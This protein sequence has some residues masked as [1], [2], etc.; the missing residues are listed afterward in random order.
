LTTFAARPENFAAMPETVGTM[1]FAGVGVD[2]EEVRRFEKLAVGAARWRLVFT[3]REAE[4]LAAQPRPAVAFC[5]AFCCKEA[6]CKALG[7]RYPFVECECR[8]APGGRVAEVELAP[9]LRERHGVGGIRMRLRE[10]Y[11]QERGE[12]VVEAHLFRPRAS[13]DVTHASPVAALRGTQGSA[14]GAKGGFPRVRSRLKSLAVISAASGRSGLEE[15]HF[16]PSEI[17][18]LGGRAVQSLAGFLALKS[19]LA[20]LWADAGAAASPRDFVLSHHPGGAPRIVEAPPGPDGVCVSIS[21]TRNWAYGL[22]AYSE[23]IA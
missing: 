18:E 9:A 8:F 14:Q 15:R 17:A 6:V 2:A 10:R 16:S 11:P 20:A 1:L 19:A 5:A 13:G 4:H 23:P 22:A 21:H 3:P 12:C 7:E